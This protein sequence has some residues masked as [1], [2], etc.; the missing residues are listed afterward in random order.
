MPLPQE[1]LRHAAASQRFLLRYLRYR[2]IAACGTLRQNRRSS[3]KSAA[4]CGRNGS[5][6]KSQ[7]QHY[8]FGVFVIFT[9]DKLWKYFA[10]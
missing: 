5:F 8:E 6:L 1:I 3:E 10:A 2:N 4:V 7:W 9:K